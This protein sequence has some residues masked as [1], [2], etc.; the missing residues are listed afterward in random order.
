MRTSRLRLWFIRLR[1]ARS[2]ANSN[3]P[4]IP[5]VA[6]TTFTQAQVDASQVVYVHDGN[7]TLSDGFSFTVDDGQGFYASGPTLLGLTELTN[8]SNGVADEKHP[9][10]SPDGTRILFF[11]NFDIY[12]MDADGTNTIQ[13]T[14]DPGSD[15]QAAWSPDGTKIVFASTRDGNHE[16]YVMDADGSNQ[17]RLTTAVG[18]DNAPVWSPDGTKIAFKSERDGD[19]DKEIFVMD[20]DGSNQTQLTFN[21]AVDGGPEWSPDGS[22]IAFQSTRDGGDYELY[23]MDA[24]GAN[25]TRLTNEAGLDA[26]P[27]WS[28]DGS[29]ILFY[30][31]RDGNNE[32][33]IMDANGSNQVR[34]TDNLDD[35]QEPVW[36]PDGSR[37]AFVTD[38]DGNYQIYTASVAYENTFAITVTPV[39]DAPVNLLTPQPETVASSSIDGV[40]D[41]HAADLNGDGDIDLVSSSYGDDRIVWYENDGAG[42]LTAIDVATGVLGARE[43]FV[44]DVDGDGHM[45]ILSAAYEQQSVVW[46]ENEVPGL[47]VHRPLRRTPSRWVRDRPRRYMRPTWTTM[48][49]PTCSSAIRIPTRSSGTKTT[50]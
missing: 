39:N 32:I 7:E 33:Y 20:A 46:Y 36:S 10:W 19:G 14:S 2:T 35:D 11:R 25:Q 1:R 31:F 8:I 23:V 49:I 24:D 42:N 21:T 37:V 48:V 41:I 22:Q 26:L 30:S 47:W 44:A 4:P 45:D 3:S 34:L 40:T 38:R 17:T 9:A 28:P 15:F 50:A 13:L 12:V 27:S 5:D 6:I 18:D 43:V 29:K 16:I